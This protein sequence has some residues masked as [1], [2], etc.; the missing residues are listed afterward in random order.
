MTGVK[1]AG[2]AQFNNGLGYDL[3]LLLDEISVDSPRD[4]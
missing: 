1:R 2:L 4:P 3:R